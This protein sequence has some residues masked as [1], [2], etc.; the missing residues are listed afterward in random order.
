LKIVI[1]F[2]YNH[3]Y[4]KWLSY[5]QSVWDGIQ[6]EYCVVGR[7]T[8]FSTDALVE[9]MQQEKNKI[10][11]GDNCYIRGRMLIYPHGGEINVGNDCYIGDFTQ[12]W[13]A[14]KITI[15]NRVLIAHN[16]NIH[17]CNDHPIDSRQR[18]EHYM[19]I[20]QYGH[21]KNI[22]S[23]D[24]GDII[25]KD[26]VWIG[27]NAVILKGVVIGENSIIA[28]GAVITKDVPSNVIVAGSPARI[29]KY[30]DEK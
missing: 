12:I 7:N 3:V 18:H 14:K 17:D 2:F 19:Q 28:A 10:L 22:Q 5:K 27:F 25:I 29:V 23:I 16:V 20:L 24:S 13:S 8:H 4:K 30:L 26:D 6:Q 11:V 1:K 15:G 9:N 21:P